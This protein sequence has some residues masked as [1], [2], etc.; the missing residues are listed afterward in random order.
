DW[1][2]AVC[3]SDLCCCSPVRHRCRVSCSH[4][5]FFAKPLTESNT[6]FAQRL[7]IGARAHIIIAVQTTEW[8][9]QII[10]EAVFIGSCH[11]VMRTHGNLVLRLTA[12]TP[13]MGCQCLVLSHG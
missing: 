12:D 6:E 8:R 13:G 11:I 4:G 2:S 5:G 3:S 7:H 9:H 1:S 10:K